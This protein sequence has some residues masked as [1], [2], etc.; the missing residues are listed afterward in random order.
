M[1]YKFHKTTLKRG[2]SYIKSPEQIANKKATINPKNTK[3]NC[4]FAYSIIVALNYRNIK[5]H[6]E[7]I[8]NIIPFVDQYDCSG[9]DFPAGI[10]DLKKFEKHNDTIALNILKVPYNEKMYVMCTKFLHSF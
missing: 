3:R 5:N 9:I 6:P 10:K 2:S 4:C 7:R 8:V 1:Q